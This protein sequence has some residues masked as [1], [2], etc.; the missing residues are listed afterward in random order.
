MPDDHR[1]E[2]RAI[3]GQLDR[4]QYREH[5]SPLFLT[6]SFTFETAGAMADT[7][8]G[9]GEGII[10]SRYNNPSVDELVGKACAM[11]GMEA[12]FATASG[13]SAVFASSGSARGAGRSHRGYASCFR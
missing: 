5:S 9:R 7:F 10:Y 13:M 8:A 6:S 3:R 4:T 2:T 1:P 11:E 12:G